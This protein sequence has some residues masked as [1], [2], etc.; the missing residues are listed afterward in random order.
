MIVSII[1][2]TF[3]DSFFLHISNFLRR[4]ALPKSEGLVDEDNKKN[5]TKKGAKVA[6]LLTLMRDVET[7]TITLMAAESRQKEGM[8]GAFHQRA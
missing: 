5:L 8:L 1:R 7:I 3:R 4:L 2:S 6:K